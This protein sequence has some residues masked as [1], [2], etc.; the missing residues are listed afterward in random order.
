MFRRFEPEAVNTAVP[1][2]V[3]RTDGSTQRGRI[4]LPFQKTLEEV[5]NGPA[6]FIEFQPYGGPPAFLAKSEIRALSHSHV[7]TP[8]EINVRLTSTSESV[9]PFDVLGVPRGSPLGEVRKAYY[10]LVKLYHP[11]RYAHAELPDEVAAYLAGMARRVNAAYAA[12]SGPH[13]V[14]SADAA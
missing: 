8:S 4:V 7:P 12:L 1:V 6:A 3:T 5:L 2:T 10:K 14:R 11:D 9:D 13:F